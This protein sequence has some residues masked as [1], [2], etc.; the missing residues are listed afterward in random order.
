MPLAEISQTIILLVPICDGVVYIEA[1]LLDNSLRFHHRRVMVITSTHGPEP[2]GKG[3]VD[4]YY[5][6][7]M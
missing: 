6:T 7:R 2:M 5:C 4:V 3:V 1:G